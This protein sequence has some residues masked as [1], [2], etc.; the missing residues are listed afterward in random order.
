MPRIKSSIDSNSAEF[1]ANAAHMAGL[2]ALL[3]Q[4]RSEAALGGPQKARERHVKRG[5][6]VPR[7]RV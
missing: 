2:V 6:L 1:K 3:K 5:K 4:R 7:D